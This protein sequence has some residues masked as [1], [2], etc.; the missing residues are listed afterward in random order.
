[1]ASTLARRPLPA[2]V[3]LL[4]LLLLAVLVWWRVLHRSDAGTGSG[5]ATCPAATSAAPA[6]TLPPPSA[7]TLK[8]LN[9]TNR[10]GIAGKARTTLAADGFQIPAPAAN[11]S[12]KIKI[13]GTA[14]IR[15]GPRA[16]KA[17]SLVRYYF[18]G[19]KM[20]P[21][22]SK[23]TVVVVSLGRRYRHVAT[24]KQVRAA[25]D[26]DHVALATVSPSGS[27]SA[28]ASC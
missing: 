27:S 25:L 13:S 5:A 22:S 26:G 6:A 8:L 15:Y 10:N 11:D 2:L 17:A 21:T 19:A 3:A 12:P 9:S 28:S 1:M 4:A 7:I 16:N 24:P 20:V 23:S 18:P 14:Q